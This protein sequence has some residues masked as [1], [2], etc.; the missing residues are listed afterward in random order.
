ME[1]ANIAKYTL[2][3]TMLPGV[4]AVRVSYPND[5][6]C[7]APGVVGTLVAEGRKQGIP[8]TADTLWTVRGT[9]SPRMPLRNAVL[10]LV[11]YHRPELTGSQCMPIADSVVSAYLAR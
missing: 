7:P 8:V 9:S 5:P 10:S 11:M 2:T 1:S 3:T 4:L 6:E